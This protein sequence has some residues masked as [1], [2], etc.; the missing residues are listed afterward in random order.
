MKIQRYVVI[1]SI[2]L[3]IVIAGSASN[4]YFLQGT[5]SDAQSSSAPDTTQHSWSYSGRGNN[6]YFHWGH[7]QVVSEPKFNDDINIYLS[8]EP[9]IAI[10]NGMRYL[11]WVDEN[12][13][14]GAGMFRDIFFKYHDGFK[15]SE[16]F[17]VSEPIEGVDQ[18]TEPSN[19]PDI[20]VENGNVYVVWQEKTDLLGAGSDEDIFF[21]VFDGSTWSAL[22]VV[23]EPVAGSDLNTRCSR[24]PSIA[25]ESGTVHVAWR[26]DTFL[27]GAGTDSD[28]FYRAR[29]GGSW[30]NIQIVSE[31]IKDADVNKVS[32]YQPSI[33]VDEGKVHIVWT[34]AN[35]TNGAGN[36]M[37]IFYRYHDGNSW[38]SIGVV[39][40]PVPGN[41][42]NDELSLWPD[43]AAENN[44]VYIVWEDHSPIYQA[45]LLETEICYR[46]LTE[47][48]WSDIEVLSEPVPGV[49]YNI[50]ESHNPKIAV[51]NNNVYVVW[52]DMNN[53]D[54]AATDEDI[55]YRCFDGV[56]WSVIQVLSE[57]ISDI[58]TNQQSSENPAVAVEHRKVHVFWDDK[59]NTDN[60]G[61]DHDILYRCTY[62]NPEFSAGNVTPT[63]GFTNTE[64]KYFIN[65]SDADNEL[66]VY[67]KIN[68]N[69]TNYTMQELNASDN[70]CYDGKTYFYNTTLN[71]ST[72]HNY[73]FW[74]TDG[75]YEITTSLYE[76]PTV[77]N[78]APNI[79]TSDNLTAFE[80]EL[81]SEQY[82]V[83][84]L[85]HWQ[86]QAWNLATNAT[87]WLNLHAQSGII[88]NGTPTNEDVGRFW[89]NVSVTDELGGVDHTNFTLTVIN[90]NDAPEITT[91]D[92]TTAYEDEL[93]N[94]HYEALDI[95]PGLANLTWAAKTGASWLSFNTTSA[96]LTGTP[97]NDEIGKFWV[98][99]SVDDGRDNDCTNFTI[100]VI[101]TNDPPM[102]ITEDVT[103]IN[104]S[105]FYSVHYEA[106]DIDPVPQYLTWYLESSAG[107]WLVMNA[108]T[109]WLYG[110]PAE[111]DAGSAWV[112]VSVR[113]IGNGS[114]FQNFT[115]KVY[116]PQN[117][118]PNI[119]IQYLINSTA[120]NE[121]Y[122]YN[123]NGTDDRTAPVNFTW[124]LTTN[125]TWLSLN[126][127]NGILNGTPGASDA[128]W[129]W[130]NISLDDGEGGI[131]FYNFT[132]NVTMHPVSTNTRPEL[133]L[134]G[135]DP[136]VGDT[137]TEFTFAVQYIDDDGD[138]PQVILVVIDNYSYDMEFVLGDPANGKYEYTTQLSIGNHT[139]YFTASDG[140]ETVWTANLTITNITL[141]L[142][143]SIEDSSTETEGFFVISIVIIII[144]IIIILI[145]FL[146]L[147]KRKQSQD[148]EKDLAEGDDTAEDESEP[149]EIADEDME[150]ESRLEPE[151]S[152]PSKPAKL[153]FKPSKVKKPAILAPKRKTRLKGA[154]KRPILLQLDESATCNVC[155]GVIKT[156][157]PVI[158]CTCGKT[159]H[160]SCADRII[161]CPNCDT[162]LLEPI[163]KLKPEK[164]DVDWVD[165]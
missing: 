126:S 125:A 56:K 58:D 138:R 92:N 111:S 15:W 45:E 19:D 76:G 146:I 124:G 77:L 152:P 69:G 16:V 135:V 149:E 3:I 13:T 98:N 28:I 83:S 71:I 63:I 143:A 137:E 11:V 139:Y 7:E 65:Y 32:S 123:F 159:Y 51:E 109:G 5:N 93:Y 75:T 148:S 108:T 10:E 33:A 117:E 36:D 29:T 89:V 142:Q 94:V 82:S 52:D 68:L 147:R 99:I 103:H 73:R 44:D 70:Y 46:A 128:G 34:D 74:A 151:D 165:D 27:N 154:P 18:S 47:S 20:A 1:I 39:S 155:L 95:D 164:D 61:T 9:A 102:I 112:N 37:D 43:V 144:I 24:H 59:N 55:F 113:D 81:Y 54:G 150:I 14:N 121:H 84:D 106:I 66:P 67:L 101:N 49:S 115:L 64:F 25:V 107:N 41:D 86:A 21:R 88:L 57:P 129:V 116:P 48:G 118:P 80:D 30:S 62:V 38:S 35:E 100:S 4:S 96:N 50:E 163:S 91:V 131:A 158:K 160:Q 132:I 145:M 90:T 12:L 105:E 122:S 110:T 40:E 119:N 161:N 22:E 120:V 153:H 157:L 141:A 2:F 114:D 17:V 133:I 6:N 162:N 156:S 127:T 140:Q 87:S 42:I 8:I 79:T 136:A 134:P 26:D 85:D 130:V 23:S 53:T 104:S 60:S 72:A 31:P 78:S 97:T